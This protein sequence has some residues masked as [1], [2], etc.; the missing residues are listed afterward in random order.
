MTIM[1]SEVKRNLETLLRATEAAHGRYEIQDLGERDQDWPIW[2]AT[3]LFDN[4]ITD[5]L[6]AIGRADVSTLAS[7]LA[8]LQKRYEREK[9]G[10]PWTEFYARR[11]IADTR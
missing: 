1:D 3:Y 2:Y 4:G 8:D 7:V 11:L 9:P 6:P 5:L 10:V